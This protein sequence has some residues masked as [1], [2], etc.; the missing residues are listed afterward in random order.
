MKLGKIEMVPLR[1]IWKNEEKDF[2][3]WL[4]QKNNLDLLSEAVGLDLIEPELEVQVGNFKCDIT[5]KIESDDR[6]VIIEN[7]IELS[8]HD[9]LGKLIVYAS[10]VEASVIIWIVKN[11]R[12][13][14]IKAIEWLNNRTDNKANFLLI[15]IELIKIGDSLP[16][17]LFKIIASPNDYAKSVKIKNELT[18][19]QLGRYNF[20]TKM[21]EY[22][23]DNKISLKTRKPSY[24]HWYNFSVGNSNYF[25]SVH[26]VD[27]DNK[28]RVLWSGNNPDKYH[29][30]KLNEY[31]TEINN[32]FSSLGTLEW[33]RKD[34]VITS[35]ISIYISN[36]S[37]DNTDNWDILF[38][39]I[40]ERIITFQEVVKQYL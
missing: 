15:E 33:D 4:I 3:P 34:N 40:I 20:W 16:A 31:K 6:I 27:Y 39:A 14:H 11:A 5:C 28:I 36:F 30:D 9:H 17:P 32:K 26:L 21:N 25:L 7:Q 35:W 10:G 13:E 23:G 1:E 38:Q 29:Y 18:R 2:S 22:F 19:A 37:F 12:S 8:N 24:D